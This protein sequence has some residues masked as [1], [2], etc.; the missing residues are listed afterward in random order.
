M[1]DTVISAL[2]G[3][4]FAVLMVLFKDLLAPFFQTRFQLNYQKRRGIEDRLK[5]LENQAELLRV[6]FWRLNQVTGI[7]VAIVDRYMIIESDVDKQTSESMNRLKAEYQDIVA[8][9]ERLFGV[10]PKDPKSV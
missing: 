9:Y 2:V 8:D 5:A 6:L 1:S 3:G 4:G 10:P 7:A